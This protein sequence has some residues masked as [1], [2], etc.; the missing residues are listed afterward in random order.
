MRDNIFREAQENKAKQQEEENVKIARE[1][2]DRKEKQ[3]I[4]DR[5]ERIIKFLHD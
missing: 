2:L 4:L 1:R 3:D 5:E